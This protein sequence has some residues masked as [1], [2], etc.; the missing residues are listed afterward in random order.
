MADPG[1][2]GVLSDAVL[3]VHRVFQRPFPACVARSYLVPVLVPVVAS[4]VVHATGALQRAGGCVW[5]VH[6]GV[7]CQGGLWLGVRQHV[8]VS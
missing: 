8:V 4:V 2:A 6:S 3:V 1:C 5:P 7:R